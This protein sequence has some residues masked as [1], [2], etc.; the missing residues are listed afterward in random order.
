[1]LSTHGFAQVPAAPS[2]TNFPAATPPPAATP[3]APAPDIVVLKN[4]A[5]YRGTIPELVPGGPVTIVLMTG[6]SRTLEAAEVAYAGPASQEPA[7]APAPPTKTDNDSDDESDDNSA[8]DEPERVPRVRFMS[9]VEHVQF[10]YHVKDGYRRLCEAPCSRELPVGIYRF[11]ARHQAGEPLTVASEAMV[12][13]P[14]SVFAEKDLHRG[15]RTTGG[16]LATVGGIVACVSVSYLLLT[17][18]ESG[19]EL[20]ILPAVGGTVAF[21]VGIGISATAGEGLDLHVRTRR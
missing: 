6:E 20:M 18:E 17:K 14:T 2:A 7:T 15:R 10:F 3:A 11:A 1:L 16:V 21:L 13:G 4:G 8:D 9:S 5:R 19:S 12:D